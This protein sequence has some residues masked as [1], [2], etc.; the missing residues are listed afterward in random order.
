VTN[1]DGEFYEGQTFRE[2]NHQEAR[3]V[4]KT[5]TDCEFERCDFTKSVFRDCRLENCR[6]RNCDLSLM[7]PL[8]CLF[9]GVLFEETKL[10]GVNWTHATKQCLNF[11]DFH[12]SKCILNYSVFMGLNLKKINIIECMARDVDFA[13]ADL[14]KAK[15]NF[16]DLTNSHFLHTNL[17]QADFTD[18]RNYA[19]DPTCNIVKKTQFSLPEA[20]ALLECFDI[21]LK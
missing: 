5:F 16:T 3:I 2:L 20:V 7:K 13:E 9:L 17:T 4:Q 18:A 6:F 10:V 19:I 1:F 21:V 14:T 12:F 8:E 15:F 11:H